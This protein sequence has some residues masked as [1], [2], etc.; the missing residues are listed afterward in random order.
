MR[1]RVL[2]GVI[3]IVV[4]MSSESA[5]APRYSDWGQP[6]NLGVV[7]NS[8]SAD[9]GPALSKDGLALYFTSRRPGGL[10]GEDLWVAQRASSQDAWGAPANLG[11]PVNTT[12]DDRVP[13]LSRDEHW[14]LYGSTRPG[15][16]GS[17]DIWASWRENVHDAF[18]WQEPVNLGPNINTAAA[19]IAPA[20]FENEGSV[21]S[22]LYF[23]STKP[24]V[25]GPDLY[26]STRDAN[27][28]WGPAILLVQLDTIWNDSR[29][30][31]RHD[32][33]ELLFMS[34]RPGGFGGLDL[35]VTT[36]A[37]TADAWS[38]PLNLGPTV[39]TSFD[40]FQVCISSDGQTLVFGSTRPGTLGF[41]DLYTS[42]RM[43]Q[44]GRPQQ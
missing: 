44:T 26:M 25:G 10:G 34:D 36:R 17:F 20:I 33:L 18:A 32:G 19:E 43:K 30:A 40:D 2:A 31:I 41:A 12:G 39:N 42:T 27:G 1:I 13:T 11:A 28:A 37:T 14:L 24:G 21:G 3:V 38:A 7:V 23:N 6:T 29:P 15:G 16:F 22:E 9:S 5:A 8:T 4:L 35:W